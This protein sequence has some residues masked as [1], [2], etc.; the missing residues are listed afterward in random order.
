MK[1]RY[2]VLAFLVGL[3]LITFLDRICFSVAAT[4]IMT[5]LK[6]DPG[7]FGWVVKATGNHNLPVFGIAVMVAIAALQFVLI[8]PDR[9]LAPDENDPIPTPQP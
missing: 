6:L 2:L 3:G 5:D 8:K 4:R 1:I 7:Q 9:S